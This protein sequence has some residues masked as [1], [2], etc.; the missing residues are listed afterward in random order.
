MSASKLV[1]KHPAILCDWVCNRLCKT[2]YRSQPGINWYK[3]QAVIYITCIFQKVIYNKQHTQNYSER[4]GISEEKRSHNSYYSNYFSQYET[5]KW[6]KKVNAGHFTLKAGQRHGWED[7]FQ[8]CLDKHS[9]FSPSV[10][11][12]RRW[13]KGNGHIAALQHSG[14][15]KNVKLFSER[16]LCKGLTWLNSLKTEWKYR[17]HFFFCL[18]FWIGPLQGFFKGGIYD[19]SMAR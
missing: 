4:T 19:C 9:L 10:F 1:S 3:W 11:L 8:G 16:P 15:Q 2:E 6:E 5:I 7:I 18:V 12:E 14:V 13:I 17:Q